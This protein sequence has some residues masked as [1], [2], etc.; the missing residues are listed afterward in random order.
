MAEEI[1]KIATEKKIELFFD[2]TL[3]KQ[4]RGLH[5]FI[6]EEYDSQER[7][8]IVVSFHD[9]EKVKRMGAKWEACT[10]RWYYLDFQPKNPNNNLIE[11]R[12]IKKYPIQHCP[13]LIS[14]A[15]KKTI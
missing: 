15:Y 9:R 3:C 6:N 7:V 11:L 12:K 1:R 10:K 14:L 4:D 8:Y 5:P 13:E 2:E